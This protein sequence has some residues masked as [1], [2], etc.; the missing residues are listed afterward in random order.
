MANLRREE[1]L[2]NKISNLNR[3]R[4]K[5]NRLMGAGLNVHPEGSAAR[6]RNVAINTRLARNIQRRTQEIRR[7]ETELIALRRR[8]LGPG[9]HAPLANLTVLH[10]INYSAEKANIDRMQQKR[11][12]R[13]ITN[14][15]LRPG[16]MFSRKLVA[17][18]ALT[19]HRRGLRATQ[20]VPRASRPRSLKR[21]HSV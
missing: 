6:W 13:L 18:V 17:N 10:G 16:G 3:E 7:L 14:A 12:A 2:V 8:L 1:K 4:G 5:V 15:F 21:A 19:A 20:S 11:L 9:P